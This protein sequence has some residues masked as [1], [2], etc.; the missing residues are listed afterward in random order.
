MTPDGESAWRPSFARPRWNFGARW[1]L[2]NR[3]ARPSKNPSA[4]LRADGRSR[5]RACGTPWH[6][7]AGAARTS[8]SIVRLMQ[9]G[10]WREVRGRIERA[11]EPNRTEGVECGKTR[12]DGRFGG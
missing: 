3:L 5:P 11:A 7:S 6:P 1:T 8:A 2:S 9:L 10:R 12:Q 4:L